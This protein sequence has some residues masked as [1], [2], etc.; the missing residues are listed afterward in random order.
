MKLNKLF[1]FALS[2]A[3]LTA[4]DDNKV[5]DYPSFLGGVNTESGV[6]VSLPTTY[7]G[8]ENEE[9]LY[10]P[11]NVTGTTNGKVTVTLQ[12]KQIDAADAP[13]GTEP[14]VEVDHYNVT[15]LTVNIPEGE[16]VGY[17]EITP[18]WETGVI[19]DDRV[20]DIE[21][22]RAEG[23]TIVN[24]LCHVTIANCDDAYTAMLGS[25]TVSG[26]LYGT[27]TPFSYD[28]T[29]KAVSASSEDYGSVLRGYGYLDDSDFF[30]PL[31][32]F[33][34]DTQ[35]QTGSVA[36]GYG[37]LMSPSFY[38]FGLS[39]YAAPFCY[40]RSGS[41]LTYNHEAV[42]TI[43]SDMTEITFPAGTN[44]YPG[45]IWYTP[46][47]QGQIQFSGYSYGKCIDDIKMT[48]N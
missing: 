10:L 24:S 25:W 48:R 22:I 14:A 16:N 9:A 42:G 18:V 30:L 34:W 46:I 44:V 20:F 17:V 35:T 43:N 29:L 19:N 5:E 7:T 37:W 12:V 8:N 32:D 47:T 23:A 45:L 41:S 36:I 28:V 6:T 40:Y 15:S 31:V 39:D 38:N 2:M 3:A 13:S 4:C 26:V 11:I 21:I 27:T 33:D 1:V